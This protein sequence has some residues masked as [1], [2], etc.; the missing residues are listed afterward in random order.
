[1]SSET[2]DN[3]LDA[4]NAQ[5]Q[6]ATYGAVAAVLNQS[7]RDLM[8][9]RE[10]GPRCSWVVSKETGMPTGYK[11]DQIH[12]DLEHRAEIL[13]TRADLERWLSAMAA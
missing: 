9:G 11:P 5:R 1:M 13:S 7:P 10:R 8:R 4:L 6:R 12:P 3:I 2:I